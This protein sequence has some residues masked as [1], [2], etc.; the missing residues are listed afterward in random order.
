MRTTADDRVADCSHIAPWL[1]VYYVASSMFSII[2]LQSSLMHDETHAAA[3]HDVSPVRAQKQEKTQQELQAARSAAAAAA[4]EVATMAAELRHLLADLAAK[5]V[6][7]PSACSCS[8]ARRQKLLRLFLS[9]A[10]PRRAACSTK[11][12]SSQRRLCVFRLA[13]HGQCI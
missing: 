9:G 1:A 8:W 10:M 11:P 6:L 3:R 2:T 4:G 12:I 13:E 5:K 7:C